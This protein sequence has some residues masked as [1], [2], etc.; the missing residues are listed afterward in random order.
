MKIFV[1]SLNGS[2]QEYNVDSAEATVRM[3]KD[4]LQEREGIPA[5]QLRIIFR[6]KLLVNADKLVDKNVSAGDT[7]HSAI[8]LRGGL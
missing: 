3:L 2:K 8:M 4:Q 6:G 5:D 7:L 1:K